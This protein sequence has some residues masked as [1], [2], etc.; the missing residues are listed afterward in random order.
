MVLNIILKYPIRDVIQFRIKA[1]DPMQLTI[2]VA[3]RLRP[4]FA[5]MHVLSRDGH[6]TNNLDI[7]ISLRHDTVRH[8]DMQVSK[9]Y[10]MESV[11][12]NWRSEL[13]RIISDIVSDWRTFLHAEKDRLQSE[14]CDVAAGLASMGDGSEEIG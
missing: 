14:L 4:L 2:L 6:P 1:T 13:D 10:K 3:E 7:L 5:A 9:T 12:D 8:P 11:D